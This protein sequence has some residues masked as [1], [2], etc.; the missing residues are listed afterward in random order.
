[1]WKRNDGRRD[2]R[3]TI[4]IKVERR[5]VAKGEKIGREDGREGM[6]AN[7]PPRAKGAL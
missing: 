2:L 7:E 1:M 4:V 5:G 6:I 3:L